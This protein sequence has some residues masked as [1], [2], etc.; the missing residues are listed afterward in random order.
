MKPTDAQDATEPL[1]DRAVAD[2]ERVRLVLAVRAAIALVRVYRAEEGPAGERE[3]AC[4]AEVARLREVLSTR[5]RAKHARGSVPAGPGLAKTDDA[6][7]LDP[8]KPS[9]L[10]RRSG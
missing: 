1:A 6:R 10:E 4:L 2:A 7:A 9:K 5:R 8:P 3:V